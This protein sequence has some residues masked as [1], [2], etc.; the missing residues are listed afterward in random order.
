MNHHAWLSNILASCLCLGPIAI[1][2]YVAWWLPLMFL[3]GTTLFLWHKTRYVD[4]VVLVVDVAGMDED[5]LRGY[6]AH[7]E[8]MWHDSQDEAG[9]CL[10]RVSLEEEMIPDDVA[11]PDDIWET[12][13]RAFLADCHAHTEGEGP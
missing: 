9:L 10:Q 6:A 3:G 13:V 1:T 7:W 2:G 12:K 4:G 5:D 8:Q 11:L